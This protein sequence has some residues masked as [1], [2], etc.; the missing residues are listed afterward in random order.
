MGIF[1][2]W[3]V[4]YC[5][6]IDKESDAIGL[7]GITLELSLV[8]ANAVLQGKEIPINKLKAFQIGF[9][10]GELN[11]IFYLENIIESEK[12]NLINTVIVY[13][14][15]RNKEIHSEIE[16][17]EL[18]SSY[19]PSFNDICID[20]TKLGYQYSTSDCDDSLIKEYFGIDNLEVSKGFKF[21]VIQA[22][23]ACSTLKKTGGELNLQTIVNLA[24]KY[25]EEIQS[26]FVEGFLHRMD[27]YSV[28]KEIVM[29]A[30]GNNEIF[31]VHTDFHGIN[32]N[33]S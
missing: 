23:G 3:E 5:K 2:K 33:N 18:I 17:E 22:E 7:I 21:G 4:N 32:K 9:I 13:W 16:A 1:S 15:A 14:H 28:D 31:F 20:I 26:N 11:K 29:I 6:N 8:S 12:I 27:L 25:H 19:K 30:K 10:L 24:H